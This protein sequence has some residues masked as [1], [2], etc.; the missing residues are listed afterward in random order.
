MNATELCIII[1]NDRDLLRAWLTKAGR[2]IPRGNWTSDTAESFA[3]T[4]VESLG[5]L[6]RG[7]SARETS[8]TCPAILAREVA[9]CA[10]SRIDWF[11]VA[12]HYRVRVEEGATA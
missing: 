11:E 5:F 10:I 6:A 2:E 8:A 7:L 4:A 1:D 12:D 3:L 9:H